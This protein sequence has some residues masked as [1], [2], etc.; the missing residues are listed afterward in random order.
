LCTFIFCMRRIVICVMV[1][2]MGANIFCQISFFIYLS[3][4]QLCYITI[5]KPYRHPK[6]NTVELLNETFIWLTSYFN[7][8]WPSYSSDP[9]VH[10]ISGW[11]YI[12]LV[13]AAVIINF[14]L[15]GYNLIFQLRIR[16][17]YYTKQR[18]S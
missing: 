14:A 1:T 3:L 18:K 12:Y 10:Y 8:I 17:N 6:Q 13:L 2:N 16:Y 4:T 11:V 15:I 5:V 7:F 9:L